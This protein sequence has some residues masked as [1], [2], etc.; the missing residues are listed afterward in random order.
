MDVGVLVELGGVEVGGDDDTVGI[1]S[2]WIRW[3]FVSEDEN[4]FEGIAGWHGHGINQVL[5]HLIV[6]DADA[7]VHVLFI[8][9]ASHVAAD[10]PVV[11]GDVGEKVVAGAP[12]TV[13]VHDVAFVIDSGGVIVRHG[14]AGVGGDI[15]ADPQFLA[16]AD[17]DGRVEVH[18]VPLSVGDAAHW[19][20]NH[21]RAWTEGA[22]GDGASGI[23]ENRVAGGGWVILVIRREEFDSRQL[24][25]D[26]CGEVVRVKPLH[27]V[28]LRRAVKPQHVVHRGLLR[29]AEPLGGTVGFGT[30]VWSNLVARHGRI[31]CKK[32]TCRDK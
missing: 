30:R 23:D 2:V 3:V 8:A 21:Q 20:R 6:E 14:V 25:P 12:W 32:I 29:P 7:E 24:L 16:G 10:F 19:L 9:G 4:G 1:L 13:V 26:M 27:R 5:V 18:D 15:D 28:K 22:A 31:L 11:D 17:G